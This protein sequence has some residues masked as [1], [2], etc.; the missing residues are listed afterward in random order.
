MKLRIG[1][2]FMLAGCS[3]GG[4]L[5]TPGPHP[6]IT[7]AGSLHHGPVELLHSP[8]SNAK[9]VTDL[10]VLTLNVGPTL[11]PIT[12]TGG[13]GWQVSRAW[14][15]CDAEGF[16]CEKLWT[17]GYTLAAGATYRHKPFRIDFRAFSYDNSPVGAQS[18][19]PLDIESL[20]LL[21]GFDL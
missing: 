18:T 10:T 5:S 4:H 14:G 6:H 1:L 2:L 19:L 11:G 9:P 13:L 12:L 16:N 8:V 7:V 3:A 17:N 21:F 15:A 20:V